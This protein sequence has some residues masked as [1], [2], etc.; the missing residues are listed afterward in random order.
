MRH[1]CDAAAIKRAKAVAIP[2]WEEGPAAVKDRARGDARAPQIEQDFSDF[3]TRTSVA[4]SA[5]AGASARGANPWRSAS[6]VSSIGLGLRRA[7]TQQLGP[8]IF[9]LYLCSRVS[10]S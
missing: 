3:K 9:M 7:S 6:L 1:F 8:T 2:L 4:A 10:P 5:P